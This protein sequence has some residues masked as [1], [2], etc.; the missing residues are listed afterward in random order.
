MTEVVWEEGS[1][2]GNGNEQAARWCFERLPRMNPDG[3][4]CIQQRLEALETTRAPAF[5]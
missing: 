2:S 1:G 3:D 5:P 4:Q